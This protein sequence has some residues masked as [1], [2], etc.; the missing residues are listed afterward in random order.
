MPWILLVEDDPAMREGLADC[1]T[2]EGYTV[3]GAADGEQAMA[4]L[5]TSLSFTREGGK[6]PA[7]ILL[8]L[9]MPVMSG[10][11]LL[12]RLRDDPRFQG[13]PVVLMSAALQGGPPLPAADGYLPK[14]FDL[15]ELLALVA[16]LCGPPASPPPPGPGSAAPPPSGAVPGSRRHAAAR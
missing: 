9:L 4:A 8:D 10:W 5:E 2:L 16:R 7:L 14:P 13:I 15:A 12:H 3:E 11:Q 1:L 6:R